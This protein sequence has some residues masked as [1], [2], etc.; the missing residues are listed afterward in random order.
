MSSDISSKELTI[1]DLVNEK[2][3]PKYGDMSTATLLS[4]IKALKNM[5]FDEL[6]DRGL[7]LSQKFPK[8][9]ESAIFD[10]IHKQKDW[11]QEKL[12]SLNPQVIEQIYKYVKAQNIVRKSEIV[13]TFISSAE[14]FVPK[15]KI[16]RRRPTP[17]N[18][19]SKTKISSQHSSS[20]S[21]EEVSDPKVIL[22]SL[23]SPPHPKSA[24]SPRS[25]ASQK[26]PPTQ[27]KRKS[28][29]TKTKRTSAPP[30]TVSKKQFEIQQ[31]KLDKKIESDISKFKISDFNS[32]MIRYLEQKPKVA[33]NGI[34]LFFQNIIQQNRKRKNKIPDHEIIEDVM[35][36]IRG[37]IKRKIAVILAQREYKKY[38]ELPMLQRFIDADI[39]P[40]PQARKSCSQKV[41]VDD[42]SKIQ[43]I[44]MLREDANLIKPGSNKSPRLL[45]LINNRNSQLGLSTTAIYPT[46]LLDI[47]KQTD[48][49]KSSNRNK[50]IDDTRSLDPRNRFFTYDIGRIFLRLG[51]DYTNIVRETQYFL[52]LY[53]FSMQLILQFVKEANENKPSRDDETSVYHN[54]SCTFHNIRHF[55]R[56]VM[57]YMTEYLEKRPL[58]SAQIN[59]KDRNV[60]HYYSRMLLAF[61]SVVEKENQGVIKY[62]DEI[63]MQEMIKKFEGL[64]KENENIFSRVPD[65]VK[66]SAEVKQ[67]LEDLQ[68]KITKAE[69]MSKEYKET[70]QKLDALHHKIDD[71]L[72]EY[73]INID[74]LKLDML[75]TSPSQPKIAPRPNPR[76]QPQ[77]P[78]PIPRRLPPKQKVS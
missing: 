14:K 61:T 69:R 40:L 35:N 25:R 52:D 31:E 42:N 11:S 3:L 23:P 73:E 8:E 2:T 65:F 56:D 21:T 12:E 4:I 28:S 70:I 30:P 75:D 36:N 63:K 39:K 1:K 32:H 60:T 18:P 5:T 20:R 54:Y 55:I 33:L 77:K 37:D 38:K 22:K 6:R 19:Q 44:K 72:M 64:T 67:K 9:F 76:V 50:L 58:I 29:P 43:I 53:H 57:D 71:D 78:K 59:E 48:T 10:V 49:G 24:S 27:S 62:A 74:F 47:F 66:H 7:I 15:L 13:E 51:D 17:A 26:I 46:N 68:G 45:K 41:P 34:V 16:K